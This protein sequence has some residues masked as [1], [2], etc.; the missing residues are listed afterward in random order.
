MGEGV[1]RCP[2]DNNIRS[3]EEKLDHE[4]KSNY[5]VKGGISGHHFP[6]T[7]SYKF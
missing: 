2:S 5:E 6:G 3:K 1:L 4:A 7:G